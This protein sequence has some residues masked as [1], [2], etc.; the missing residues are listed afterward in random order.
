MARRSSISG[1]RGADAQRA[2]AGILTPTAAGGSRRGQDMDPSQQQ[3]QAGSRS[4]LSSRASSRG[5][6]GRGEDGQILIEDNVTLDSTNRGTVMI[7]DAM[8]QVR[9][10]LV[11]LKMEVV[12]CDKIKGKSAVTLENYSG[13]ISLHSKYSFRCKFKAYNEKNKEFNGFMWI[14]NLTRDTVMD[15]L[16]PFNIQIHWLHD[17]SPKGIEYNQIVAVVKSEATRNSFRQQYAE[18][19]ENILSDYIPRFQS[20]RAGGIYMN[21]IGKKRA[22][23]DLSLIA[24]AVEKVGSNRYAINSS[25]GGWADEDS[26][27]KKRGDEEEEI[28]PVGTIR[29]RPG[30]PTTPQWTDVKDRKDRKGRKSRTGTAGSNKPGTAGSITGGG[31]R[32]NTAGSM[33]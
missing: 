7:G 17:L 8:R 28:I 30:T 15:L 3:Q 19:E 33:K 26:H 4:A 1:V 21:L 13:A 22:V 2:N 23:F 27:R 14:E 11:H 5:G 29:S 24:S 12:D 10:K 16:N 32:T 31:S 9:S 20:Q 18:Y 25:G 6:G